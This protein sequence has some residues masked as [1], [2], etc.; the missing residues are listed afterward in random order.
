MKSPS[1][2][3][4]EL[5]RFFSRVFAE[6]PLSCHE[7]RLSPEE[8]RYLQVQYTRLRLIPLSSA[9]V[10]GKTWFQVCPEGA[11]I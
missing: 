7:M 9:D 1:F 3:A 6:A 4:P 8:A 11:L 10:S 2:D 5:N